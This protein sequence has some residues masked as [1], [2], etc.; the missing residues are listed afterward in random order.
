MKKKVKNFISGIAL[1]SALAVSMSA[2]AFADATVQEDGT[3]NGSSGS[4]Q[5]QP[6]DTNSNNTTSGSTTGDSS[7]TNVQSSQNE[8]Q[9]SG[10]L[11]VSDVA[12]VKETASDAGWS[13]ENCSGW[14]Y[15]GSSL[16]LVNNSDAS[17]VIKAENQGC[18]ISVAGLNRLGTL[19]AD[20]DVNI[21]G[22]GILLIDNVDMLEGTNINLL[23]NTKMY[24]DGAGSVSL[25][26]KNT[27]DG[28]YYLKNG[29]VTGILDDNYVIPE[30]FELVIE[31]G[32]SIELKVVESV[33]VQK[34]TID[35]KNEYILTEEKY[36]HYGLTEYD[37]TLSLLSEPTAKVN[38]ETDE[39]EVT[40]QVVKLM[41]P[42]LTISNGGKLTVANGG[43]ITL[44]NTSY[45]SASNNTMDDDIRTAIIVN[46]T[47]ENNGNINGTKSPNA[48]PLMTEIRL[49]GT[50]N[51]Y[52]TG[53]VNNLDIISSTLTTNENVINTTGECTLSVTANA[54]S[55][56]V[57]SGNLSIIST[58]SSM[59]SLT[60][61]DGS[62]AKIY[63]HQGCTSFYLNNTPDNSNL[64]DYSVVNLYING[65]LIGV[66][67]VAS[68]TDKIPVV[69]ANMPSGYDYMDKYRRIMQEYTDNGIIE[70]YFD[71]TNLN[72][73]VGYN[74]LEPFIK[75]IDSNTTYNLIRVLCV[76]NGK[77]VAKD[78]TYKNGVTVS[79]DSIIRII[80]LATIGNANSGPAAGSVQT[81]SS[82]TGAAVLGGQNASSYTGS[83][84]GSV[85]IG[86]RAPAT[87]NNS[88]GASGSAGDTAGSGSGSSNNSN[89]GS[90]TIDNTI[91]Q[92]ANGSSASGSS[93]NN[94][95][96]E[97][98]SSNTES[99]S[100]SGT[101][102]NE[103]DDSKKTSAS[104]DN[105]SQTDFVASV[106]GSDNHFHVELKLGN[107]TL[108]TLNGATINVSFKYDLPPA[109]SSDSIYVV[110]TKANGELIII[111]ANYDKS[112]GTVSFDTPV[113]GDF[114]LVS[115]PG[116]EFDENSSDFINAVKGEMSKF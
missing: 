49:V 89:G 20:G 69:R 5:T 41:F 11:S 74:D 57:K 90:G 17:V 21:T 1:S 67:P 37:K 76:E 24:S 25:F 95:S 22:S 26:V 36:D 44:G 18:D 10:S 111:K 100:D 14:R 80:Y 98:G 96:S 48:S 29:S 50:G 73:N 85:S 110:F 70:T 87:S 102:S 7:S 77:A 2:P 66:N 81:S 32:S 40:K 34:F 9:T 61:S 30:G 58:N 28:K 47:L 79:K 59:D 53:N 99:S 84:A 101:V 108:T 52:G 19:Y 12:L 113:S 71:T 63:N 56:N 35:E 114:C 97:T 78:I 38:N 88:S 60:I 82:N 104:A 105:A 23:T 83:K 72:T 6:A 43:S 91:S 45:P 54:P 3:S 65:S 39:I 27:K 94:S 8:T 115:V 68:E 33:Y 106:S 112:T 75:A 109:W 86:S 13:S 16:S 51:I 107:D 4:T 31:N 93:T 62:T 46:G 103:K 92:G 64:L 55:V 116:I 42:T 15:D